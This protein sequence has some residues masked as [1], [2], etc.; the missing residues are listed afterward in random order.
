MPRFRY[1]ASDANG[2]SRSGFIEA[3]D[4]FSVRG[5]LA[6]QGLTLLSLQPSDAAA[7]HEPAA[8]SA[9]VRIAPAEH[10]EVVAQVG[11][12][13]SA[14]VPL[15]AGLR[16]LS[17][18]VPSKRLRQVFGRLSEKL[19]RGESLEDA[20][21][22]ESRDLPEWLTAV[23]TA[24]TRS[25]SLP[26]CI[27]HYITF[28]RLRS[29]IRGKLI[30]SLIYPAILLSVG[31]A[32]W[33]LLCLWLIPQ[34]RSIFEGFG[35][36]LPG[37]TRSLLALSGACE[38]IVEYWWISVPGFVLAVGG[39]WLAA[40]AVFGAAVVRRIQ[41][42]IPLLGRVLKLTALAEF[43]QLLA[44]LIESRTPLHEALRLVGGAVRDPNLAEGAYCAA[45]CLEKGES[46]TSLRGQVPEIPDELFRTPGWGADEPCLVES[47]QVSGE[48]FALQSEIS[49]RGLYG[50]IAPIAVVFAG[51]MIVLTIVG[52]FTP[53]VKLLNDLS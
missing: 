9:D 26:E 24:G 40:K 11:N 30:I 42:H 17:E 45:D 14:G 43:A 27:Q 3:A 48:V 19:D 35:V 52:L 15:V 50:L 28:S 49:G 47:L 12:L 10:V 33:G 51:G 31:F 39:S 36:E 6:A 5:Q 18:E 13:I 2:E 37:I 21:A 7:S 41:Y 20:M 29:G 53:L 1:T 8:N 46:F 23:F 4:E 38:M 44:L 34:F 16:T 32:V 25:G 22:S